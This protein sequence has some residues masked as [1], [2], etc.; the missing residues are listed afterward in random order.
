MTSPQEGATQYER[1]VDAMAEVQGRTRRIIEEAQSAPRPKLVFVYGRTS[2]QS[3]RVEGFLAQVL[4][5]R[6][7]HE[8]FQL[9]RVCAESHPE[10]VERLQVKVLPTILVIQGRRVRSRVESPRGRAEIEAG[11][12]RWLK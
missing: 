5:R 10:L 11:L 8:T 12:V 3:R 6:H 1:L 7:N 9:V 4:Q 2:G